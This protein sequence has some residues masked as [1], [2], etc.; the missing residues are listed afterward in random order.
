AGPTTRRF[1]APRWSVVRAV[2]GAGGVLEPLSIAALPAS[3]ARVKVGPPLFASGPRFRAA[4]NG[5]LLP[6]PAAVGVNP[7]GLPTALKVRS[8]SPG[9]L[10]RGSFGCTMSG[11]SEFVLPEMMELKITSGD[12]TTFAPV[13]MA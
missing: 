1:G 11:A 4:P 9:V 8:T 13:L 6:L 10:V 3:S 7:F 5:R 2:K 12:G